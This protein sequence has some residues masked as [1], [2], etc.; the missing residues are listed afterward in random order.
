MMSSPIL[1]EENFMQSGPGSVAI[2]ADPAKHDGLPTP[3]RYLAIVAVS[4]GTVLTTVD[5]TIVNVALPTLAHDL[6]VSSSAAVLVVTI[7]Q[8]VM[9]TMMMPCSALGERFGFRAT[10]QWGQI[11]FVAATVLCFFARSLPVLVLVRAIQALGA[12]VTLSVSSA[13]IRSIYPSSMLGRGLSLNTLIAATAASF[14]PTLGGAILAVAK[15]PWVF[16]LAVPFGLLSI[17]IGRKALPQANSRGDSYDVPGAVMCAATFA[18]A[19]TGFQSAAHGGPWML[20]AVLFALGFA[21]G[22]VF[23]RRETG[24]AR[25]IFAVDLLRQKKI[26]LSSIGL[27][28]AFIGSMIVMLTL[29]FRMQQQFNYTP[30]ESGAVLIPWPLSILAVAPLSG[31]LSDRIAPGILGGIG[32][33]IAV[34]GMVSLAFLP[35]SPNHVDLV[36]RIALCGAGFAMYFSPN[37]RQIIGSAPIKRAA[38]AGAL[39][40]SIRQTGQTL[41]STAV[42]AMLAGGIGTGYLPSLFAAAFGLIAGLCSLAV[43]RPPNR[44]AVFVDLP[45]L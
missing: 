45:E 42:A 31:M 6:H 43:L 22:I 3:R 8:L 36:W 11:I 29:P 23:V 24:R 30:A 12:A 17:A 35:A 15:W 14:A 7:Y 25:P 44:R 18:L 21:L 2:H 10:Y 32:M 9:M 34:A 26:A 27:L 1:E 5:G 20:T 40:A 16:A 37:A 13:M 4:L 33:C 28:A 39:T 38:A 41:G 19:S